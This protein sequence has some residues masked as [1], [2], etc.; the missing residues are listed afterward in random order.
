MK[1]PAKRIEIPPRDSDNV[2]RKLHDA[3]APEIIEHLAE[4]AR[5]KGYSKHKRNP[6]AFKLPPYE[7]E[8]GDATLCDEHAGFNPRQM[9]SIEEILKRGI[10]AGL[11]G[12][13]WAGEVPKL[14]WCIGNDGWIFEARLTNEAIAEYH[15]YPVRPSEAIARAVYQRYAA[16]AHSK[17]GNTEDRQVAAMCKDLYGI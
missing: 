17:H 6:R 9:D 14:L 12:S 7:K 13:T 5:Y 11:V 16:W 10:R 15:G 2:K 1:K 8:R 3:P 4:H